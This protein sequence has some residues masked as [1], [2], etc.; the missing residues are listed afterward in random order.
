MSIHATLLVGWSGTLAFMAAWF[1]LL[2]RL[3]PDER[4]FRVFA[5]YAITN[6]CGILATATLLSAPSA[7]LA[8]TSR[9]WQLAAFGVAAF[10]LPELVSGLTRRDVRVGPPRVAG[11]I[12]AMLAASGLFVD[13]LATTDGQELT[14][15]GT[16]AGLVLGVAVTPVTLTLTWSALTQRGLGFVA[17]A[18]GVALVGGLVDLQRLTAGTAPFELA[19]H[20]VGIAT[21][22]I[23]ATLMR[24][25]V[26]AEAELERSSALL[27]RSLD[28][29]R[30]AERALVDTKSRAAIG[31]LAAVIAH[32]VRNPLAVLRNAASSLRKPTTSSVDIETLVEIV[33]E[34]TRRLD[35]L[36]RSLAH[37]A[38]PMPYRPASVALE[39]LLRDVTAAVRRAHEDVDDLT[40][41]VRPTTHT[42]RGDAA[43]LRQALVNV[44]DNAVRA[45]PEG[46]RVEVRAEHVDDRVRIDV[47]DE[48]EGMTDAVRARA[49]DPFFTT[50]ATG[51][52]LGLALVDKVVR[53]HGGELV[54]APSSPRGTCVSITL[55]A[56]TPSVST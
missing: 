53:L 27:A 35:Q 36:G 37:Y 7:S 32:E 43:L 52:G 13:P 38:E 42:V 17:L 23:G 8:A 20:A 12:F 10:L 22:A 30:T 15:V 31:E 40:L 41:D 5:A 56:A 29:L 48:G 6:A 24:R 3:R 33:Q 50:R 25:V 55:A 54:L 28:E 39:P 46:G 14:T 18:L 2:A 9:S 1:A 19:P 26:S 51:T 47:I 4:L 34:E 45:M 44:V 21:I 11:A 16:F 49:R